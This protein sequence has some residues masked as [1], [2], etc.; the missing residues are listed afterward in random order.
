MGNMVWK[1]RAHSLDAFGGGATLVGEGA[2]EEEALKV[3]ILGYRGHVGYCVG[4]CGYN[5]TGVKAIKAINLSSGILGGKGGWE[6]SAELEGTPEMANLWLHR[7]E[8]VAAQ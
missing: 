2:T 7:G 3:A 6:V 5:A 4:G 8:A 1:F